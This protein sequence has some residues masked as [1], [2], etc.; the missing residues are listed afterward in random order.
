MILMKKQQ[1]TKDEQIKNLKKDNIRFQAEIIILFLL[2][3]ALFFFNYN[4]TIF[5]ILIAGNYTDTT[6]LDKI[7]SQTV[8]A[9][10][11]GNYYKDFDSVTIA[12]F[13][14]KLHQINGDEFTMLFKKGGLKAEQTQMELDSAKSGFKKINATTGI[15][16]LTTFSSPTIKALNE[17]SEQI[18]SC[19]KLIIDLRDNPGGILKDAD[20]AA[21]LFL[22]KGAV[23]AHYH[24]RSKLFSSVSI[25]QNTAPLTFDNIYILQNE[26]TASAAEVF[27]NALAEN[28]NNVMIIGSSSYGKGI[29]QTEMK[30]LNGFGIKATTLDILTPTGGSINHKGIKP[31]ITPQGDELE[32]A[33]SLCR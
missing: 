18:K 4:Y 7:Y 21:E 31:D 22:A 1:L 10:A 6:A 14:D 25:S 26:Y 32:Y 24:Y 28:L 9:K 3:L 2:L 19:N 11:N 29:G 16:T 17:N 13:M 5:K 8:S 23:I 12:L 27:I 20:K 30:L 15:L 33:V